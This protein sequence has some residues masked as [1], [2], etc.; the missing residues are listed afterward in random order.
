MNSCVS[1][2]VFRRTSALND[3]VTMAVFKHPMDAL[4]RTMAAEYCRELGVTVNASQRRLAQ[5][6]ESAETWIRITSDN[7]SA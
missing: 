7:A 6:S 3:L 2:P 4:K 5:K 1:L